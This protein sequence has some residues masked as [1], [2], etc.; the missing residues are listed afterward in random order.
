[1]VWNLIQNAVKFTPR[2]GEIRVRSHNLKAAG[3]E[4]GPTGGASRLIIEVSDTGVGIE[5]EILPRIF[6]AFEQGE[7]S[8]RRRRGG[9]GLGLAISRSLAQAHGG[10]LSAASAGKGLGSTFTLEL[11]TIPRP[12]S[13]AAGPAAAL[14]P[15]RP[16]PQRRPLRILLVEDNKD[17]LRSL[18]RI[19]GQRGYHVQTAERLSEAMEA[20]TGHTYDLVLSDIELPDGTGLELMRN[21]GGKTA[22]GIAM[23]GYGSEEDIQ[24]SLA[25]GYDEHLT[26]PVD[27]H[28]LE[29]AIQRVTSGTE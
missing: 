14:R 1:M 23:S 11:P 8:L 12:E 17:T 4:L 5:P 28:R 9:L 16:Q 7:D 20:A 2:G 3:A 24:Q 27:I 21:L 26:K 22:H 10:G 25:A 18:S 6:D 29:Q 19:L 13:I 15:P